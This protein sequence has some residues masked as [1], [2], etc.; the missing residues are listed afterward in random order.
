ML[1]SI[2]AFLVL[3]LCT[4]SLYADET[5]MKERQFSNQLSKNTPN[6]YK[7]TA[8]TGVVYKIQTAVGYV[9]TIELPDEALKVFLGDQDLF[10]VEVYGHQVIVKPATDYTDART[11]LTLYTEN[12]RLS[13]DVSVGSPDTA[14]FV[15]DFRYPSD[16]A[17]VENA[18]KKELEEKK[19][20]L[21]AE[22]QEK[23]GKEDEKINELTH[24]RFEDFLKKEAKIK[25]LK[26]S[27]NK[28]NIQLNLLSLSEIGD[29]DYL[30]FNIM[31]HSEREYLLDR[32]VFAK[33]ASKE[34]IVPLE[35][36]E[37]VE[38]SVSK[39]GFEYGVVS[40]DKS[41]VNPN[42]KFVLRLYEKDKTEPL[43]ISNMSLED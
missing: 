30:R 8:K 19:A 33:E 29:R 7:L 22:Y 36:S 40:F 12:L 28:D 38:P 3:I 35:F 16:E 10:V 9:T 39:G 21:E 5:P 15:L 6:I 41:L 20:Q 2:S 11:N 18:F 34:S 25:R 4:T 43:E 14:D 1:R 13:F 24:K 31:N 27:K 26:I 42:D 17:I 37:S 32:I 23:L